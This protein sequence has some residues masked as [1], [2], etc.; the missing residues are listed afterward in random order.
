MNLL[1]LDV[2][3]QSKSPMTVRTIFDAIIQHKGLDAESIDNS[4]A[5]Q[6]SI[7]KRLRSFE[8]DN[9]VEKLGVEDSTGA[10]QWSV[11]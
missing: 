3:R 5:I 8:K 10:N 1:I 4:K 6:K 11:H 9:T 2:L 7:D